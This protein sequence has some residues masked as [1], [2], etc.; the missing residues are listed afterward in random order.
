MTYVTNQAFTFRTSE[1]S[2][3]GT[4]TGEWKDG[5]PHGEGTMTMKE[6]NN[7]RWGYGDTLWSANWVNGLIEGYGQWRS[8]EMGGYYNGNFSAGLKNGY[9]RMWFDDGTVYDGQWR[10]GA[11]VG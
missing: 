6:R 8:T 9:G 5:K 1:F 4:Y 10:N 2:V 7:S 3:T 11:F